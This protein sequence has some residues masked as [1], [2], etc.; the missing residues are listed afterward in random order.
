MEKMPSKKYRWINTQTGKLTDRETN[1]EREVDC[2][3]NR[4]M[5]EKLKIMVVLSKIDGRTDRW[6]NKKT[7]RQTKT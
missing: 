2:K 7:D 6:T 1:T 5:H 4:Q 3:I